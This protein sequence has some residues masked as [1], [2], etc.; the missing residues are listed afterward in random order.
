MTQATLNRVA[1]GAIAMTPETALRL[2]AHL[3]VR[4]GWLLFGE[5]D[6][7]AGLPEAYRAG[8]RDGIEAA[9]RAIES[10]A[11]RTELT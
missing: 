3:G 8:F 11:C 1:S 6:A 5:G 4:A 9:S 2:A 7:P 10:V